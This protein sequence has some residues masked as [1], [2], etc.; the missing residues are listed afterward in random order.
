[1]LSL[2]YIQTHTHTHSIAC[3]FSVILN[4]VFDIYSGMG[5]AIHIKFS[6][7][8]YFHLSFSSLKTS[9]SRYF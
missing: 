4:D 2:T 6:Y 3:N 8:L 9:G 1:M 5:G 7:L